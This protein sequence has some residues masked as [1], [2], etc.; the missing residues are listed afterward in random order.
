MLQYKK[1]L[2]LSPGKTSF[3]EAQFLEVSYCSYSGTI[4]DEQTLLFCHEQEQLTLL[5]QYFCL[6]H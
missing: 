1:Q 5:R 2:Q 3:F 6:H 4:M